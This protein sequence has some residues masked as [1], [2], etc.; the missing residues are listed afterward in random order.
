MALTANFYNFSKRQNSTK[1]PASAGTSFSITLK[2]PT[3]L[4]SPVFM[5]NSNTFGYNYCQFNGAYYFVSDIVSIR[6][7]IWEVHCTK[8][9]LATYRTEI[10]GST[11]YVL[12]DSSA[13]SSIV[14]TRLAVESAY[15]TSYAQTEITQLDGSGVYALCVVGAN[16]TDTWIVSDTDDLMNLLST[17]F[18][19]VFSP[20]LPPT[21]PTIMEQL[22]V[23]IDYI[24]AVI[25][26]IFASGS[27]PDCVRSCYW[28]PWNIAGDSGV[29][30]I[31]LGNFRTG[32]YGKRVITNN[33]LM[34]YSVTIPWQTN[35][36]RRISPYTQVYLYLPFIG[37]INI[38][39]ASISNYSSLT[40]E[41]SLAKRTGEVSVIVS[42]DNGNHFIGTYQGNSST[43]I[44]IGKS[45]ATPSAKMTTLLASAGAAAAVASGAGFVGAAALNGLMGNMAALM[46]GAPSCVGGNSG[47]SDSGL[48]RY[49]QCVTVLHDTNVTPSTVASTIG[50]PTFANRTLSS[51]SGYVQTHEFSLQADAP[52]VDLQRVNTYLNGGAFIE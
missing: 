7:D 42:A 2:Q 3:S 39:S 41:Y 36:W 49:I 14:D 28:L 29:E 40:V 43:N 34:T 52:D 35:D 19:A 26:N 47:G 48:P 30:E 12:Y 33:L 21:Q 50:T 11:A 44:P 10:L 17:S 25:G 13:N 38:P 51:I 18:D 16:S 20:M 6:N 8:D 24:T 1:V 4:N 31:K 22:K 9:V 5:L 15:T 46:A 45:A 27:A 23:T 32:Q 37:I